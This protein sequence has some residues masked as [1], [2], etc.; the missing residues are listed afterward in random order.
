[1]EQ[2]IVTGMTCAACQARVEKARALQRERFSGTGILC[3]AYMGTGE[4]EQF[5]ALDDKC[6]AL[7]KSAYDRMGLTARSYHRILRVARTVAD[8]DGSE[9]IAPRHLAEA[10]QYRTFKL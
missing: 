10:I 6:S 2:Y 7:M 4:L 1:M 8:L 9:T 5:C 3:N